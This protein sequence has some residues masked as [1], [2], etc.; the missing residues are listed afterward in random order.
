MA[1]VTEYRAILISLITSKQV[2]REGLAMIK[3][4]ASISESML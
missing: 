2:Y 1:L 3:Q 4:G